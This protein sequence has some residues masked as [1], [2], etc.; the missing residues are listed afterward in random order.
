MEGLTLHLMHSLRCS[1][2]LV[3]L[4]AVSRSCLVA[5]CAGLAQSE[6]NR[7]LGRVIVSLR[8]SC[9]LYKP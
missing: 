9:H 4:P 2:L 5:C 7:L 6:I 3:V 8:N 1:L